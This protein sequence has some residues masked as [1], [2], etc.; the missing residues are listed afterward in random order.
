MISMRLAMHQCYIHRCHKDDHNKATCKLPTPSTQ[1]TPPATS[2]QPTPTTTS[3][4]PT[5]S[6]TSTHPTPIATSTQQMLP[7]TS[8]QPTPT[9]TSTQ[10]PPKK[11]RRLQK[12]LKQVLSQ[13]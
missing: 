5:L 9:A 3:T 12:G 10:Q 6:T 2:T 13:S 1:P 8:T 11:K 7:A 4:Q